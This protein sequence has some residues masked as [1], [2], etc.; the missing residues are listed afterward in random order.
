MD[1]VALSMKKIRTVIDKK[2]IEIVN[3]QQ[4]V[5]HNHPPVRFIVPNC[6]YCTLY[7]NCFKN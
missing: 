6:E 3:A 5:K 4:S 7:G 1:Y 2:C